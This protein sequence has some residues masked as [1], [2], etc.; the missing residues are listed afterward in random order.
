MARSLLRAA[1]LRDEDVMEEAE[2]DAW[3][4]VNLVTSGTVNFQDGTISGTGDVYAGSYHGDGS[5]LTGIEHPTTT[6]SGVITNETYETA[7]STATDTI[8]LDFDHAD[9]GVAYIDGVRQQ[10]DAYVFSGT[11]QI[12][13]DE[14]VPSGTE[15]AFTHLV[16]EDTEIYYTQ[17]QV[18]AIIATVSG[19]LQAQ[20]DQMLEL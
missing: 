19:A 9:Y 4:H 5:N 12:V 20:I 18:D 3:V 1:Q 10:S 8:T 11:D 16:A 7:T 2:H 14:A 13:F 6:L 15:V 17:S